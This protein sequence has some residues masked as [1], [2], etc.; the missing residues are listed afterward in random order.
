VD[1]DINKDNA[2]ATRRL[3]VL[4]TGLTDEHLVWDLGE[5]WTVAVALAHAAFWDRRAVVGLR[6]WQETGQPFDHLDDEIYNEVLLEEWLALPP[7]KALEMALA[8]ARAVDASVEALPDHLASELV[9]RDMEWVL[10][11]A[12]HRREHIDQIEARLKLS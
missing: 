11:R 8:G 10:R 1:A 2:D 9:A 7:R 4:T 3:E 12:G 5:G 6:R